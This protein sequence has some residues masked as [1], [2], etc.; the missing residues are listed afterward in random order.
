MTASAKKVKDEGHWQAAING[1]V[2]SHIKHDSP[3][4]ALYAAR[5]LV[6]ERFNLQPGEERLISEIAK[7]LKVPR[8]F[9]EQIPDFDD[10]EDYQLHVGLSVNGRA[11][12]LAK[13]DWSL[14]RSAE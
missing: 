11:W 3:Q 9:I 1:K 5:W 8:W 14:H 13:K 12:S 10:R 7:Q 6:V 4:M 2:V